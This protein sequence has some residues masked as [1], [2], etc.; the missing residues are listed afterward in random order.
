MRTKEYSIKL[1]VCLLSPQVNSLL[2]SVYANT[3]RIPEDQPLA[4]NC[5]NETGPHDIQTYLNPHTLS[6]PHTCIRG[7]TVELSGILWAGLIPRGDSAPLYPPSVPCPVV[8]PDSQPITNPLTQFILAARANTTVDPVDVVTYER[9]VHPGGRAPVRCFH[10]NITELVTYR[11]DGEFSLEFCT[12]GYCRG[13]QLSSW[14]VSDEEYPCISEREGVLCGQ[15]RSG[16][17]VTT[18]STVSV[19]LNTS[20]SFSLL[21]SPSIPHPSPIPPSSPP[22]LPLFLPPSLPLTFSYPVLHFF[23]EPVFSCG[24]LFPQTCRDCRD[25]IP[26]IPVLLTLILGLV[27]VIAV[28]AFNFEASPTIDSLLFFTQVYYIIQVK[29]PCVLSFTTGGVHT[30]CWE[31]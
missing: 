14:F 6:L 26:A 4:C 5:L 9:G 22:S 21:P 15:C 1:I 23:C 19:S 11:P 29:K 10:A 3:Q 17:A 18:Y 31:S 27:F 28:V 24:I 25:A 20:D 2:T 30:P 16:F 8:P 12:R 7:Y 13:N